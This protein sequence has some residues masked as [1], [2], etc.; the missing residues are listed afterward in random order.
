MLGLPQP[1]SNTSS[2]IPTIDFPDPSD[3]LKPFIQYL[4][5]RP[6]PKVIG[7][8]MWPALYAVAD[9]YNVEV[10]TELLRA[11]LISQFLET[12]PLRVYALASRWGLEQEAKIASRRTLTMDIL[13][14]FPQ[15][16]AELMS[17]AACQRLVFLHLNR[18]EAARAL[19][20]KHPLPSS[21]SRHCICPPSNYNGLVPALCH[22]VATRPWL[23]A[24]G[25]YEEVGKRSYPPM[26][27]SEDCRYAIKNMCAY[28][29]SLLKGISDLPQTI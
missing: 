7:I 9:K 8:S 4:Y 5:P 29:T 22:H 26:C 14:E 21:R 10:V 16:E 6:P 11:N 27:D 19:V 17:G 24:E 2:Q 12:Y 13:S 23:T 25:L 15:E 20:A 18:R 3:I 1:A 28:F